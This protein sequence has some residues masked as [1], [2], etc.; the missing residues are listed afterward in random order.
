MEKLLIHKNKPESLKCQFHIE[1][2][3]NASDTIVRLCLEFKDNKNLFFNGKLKEDGTCQ[4][5]IPILK[6]L[7]QKEGKAFIEVV[8]DSVYFKVYEA[9]L[10]IKNSIEV[11]LLK[12]E[13]NGEGIKS[14]PKVSINSINTPV[15]LVKEKVE[16]IQEDDPKPNP[17]KN[18]QKMNDILENEK[19]KKTFKKTSEYDE[20]LRQFK[21]FVKS[22]K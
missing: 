5:D 14:T 3:D 17:K 2:V 22:K 10:E 16:P 15:D 9:E 4:I 1:G 8:A 6:D 19:I 12:T 11:Q 13:T 7:N 20:G 18:F 21:E